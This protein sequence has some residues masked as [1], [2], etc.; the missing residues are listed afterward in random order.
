MDKYEIGK[1]LKS[2]R[3]DRNI[4]QEMVADFLGTT[5]QKVS[6]FETGR[7]R[8]DLETFISLCSYYHISA[9]SFFDVS[10][11]RTLSAPEQALLDTYRSLDAD[12]KTAL[13]K[14]ADF[15]ASS[16]SGSE[17]SQEQVG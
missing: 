1:K 11:T 6:S 7:T 4:S 13:S 3:L 8:V 5:C 12:G 14:Y 2:I 9:D 10:V 16:S 15:L 17:D